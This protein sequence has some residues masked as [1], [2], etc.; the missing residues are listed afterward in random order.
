MISKKR[1][2]KLA[3]TTA[4]QMLRKLLEGTKFQN[5]LKYKQVEFIFINEYTVNT[6]HSRF[7]GWSKRSIKE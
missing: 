5:C 4:N 3:P 7:K 2:I 6:I 1:E